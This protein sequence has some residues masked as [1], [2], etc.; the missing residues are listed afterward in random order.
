MLE[1]WGKAEEVDVFVKLNNQ[2]LDSSAKVIFYSPAQLVRTPPMFYFSFLSMSRVHGSIA[3]NVVMEFDLTK[4]LEAI[5][6]IFE[7]LNFKCR[8]S[9]DQG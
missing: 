6:D 8:F 5:E 9:D 3:V 7:A 4:V 1:Y 2:L